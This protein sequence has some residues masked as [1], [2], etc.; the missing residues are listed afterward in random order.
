VQLGHSLYHGLGAA[1]ACPGRVISGPAIT[2]QAYMGFAATGVDRCGRRF[3]DKTKQA[4]SRS[5]LE[6]EDFLGRLPKH[7]K[8]SMATAV[9]LDIVAYLEGHYI[10]NHGRTKLPNGEV[11]PAFDTVKGVLSAL[12]RGFMNLGRTG[13]WSDETL[14]GCPRGGVLVSDWLA[15]YGRDL[16]KWGYEACA[17]YPL[18][19]EKRRKLVDYIDECRAAIADTDPFGAALLEE[20]ALVFCYLWDSIQRGAEGARLQFSDLHETDAG[21]VAAPSMIKNRKRLR[22]GNILLSRGDPSDFLERLP[23]WKVTLAALG[24]PTAGAHPV[25]PA[26][27]GRGAAR[28]FSKDPMSGSTLYSRLVSTLKAAGLYEGESTHS[29]RR[30]GVQALVALGVPEHEIADRMLI[31]TPAVVREYADQTRRTRKRQRT[32]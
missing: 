17:A 26:V 2:G 23:A 20:L 7:W 8:R 10:W 12:R 4:Y 15:G 3:E 6:F 29:F 32:T 5:V 1:A 16:F 27:D 21:T 28:V 19:D 24:R 31:S 30:G 18:T 13:P 22:C 9:P 14:T 25:F 11:V